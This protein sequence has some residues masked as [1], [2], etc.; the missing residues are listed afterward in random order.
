MRSVPVSLAPS[1]PKR[2]AVLFA[3][4]GSRFAL[5]GPS[6]VETATVT[7]Y[8]PIRAEDPANLGVTLYRERVIPLVDLD[9]RLDARSSPLPTPPWRCLFVKTG[10]GEVGFPIDQLLGLQAPGDRLP[11]GVILLDLEAP[12][13]GLAGAGAPHG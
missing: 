12:A 7:A 13:M 5:P 10:L 6:V 1:T 4:G 2:D 9:R 11:D 3:I 8:T